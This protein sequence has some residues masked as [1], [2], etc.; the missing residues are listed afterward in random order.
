MDNTTPN[1]KQDVLK[2]IFRALCAF[3]TVSLTVYCVYQYML[4]EDVARIE[5]KEFNSGTN[6]IYPA[7]TMC[8]RSPLLEH[9][10]EKYGDGINVNTYSSFLIGDHWDDRMVHINYDDVSI[11]FEDYLLG[12]K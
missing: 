7:V 3:A 12:K 1:V 10:L 8:F 5:F 9:E 2:Y 4:D 6:D 11:K